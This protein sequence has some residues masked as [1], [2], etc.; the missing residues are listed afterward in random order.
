LGDTFIEYVGFAACTISKTGQETVL[1]LSAA[2]APSAVLLA[3]L[4]HRSP[5]QPR[6]VSAGL[7]AGSSSLRSSKLV[8]GEIVGLTPPP[9]D[10]LRLLTRQ[11]LHRRSAAHRAGQAA[12]QAHREV[13]SLNGS[14][15]YEQHR[16]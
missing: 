6:L 2:E 3:S 4:A 1:L 15:S 14:L 12:A 9:S 5:R 10:I 7:L 8:A 11:L 16:R 13:I